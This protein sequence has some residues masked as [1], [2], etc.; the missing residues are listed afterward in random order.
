[1][2]VEW[3]PFV[4]RR[5]TGGDVVRG[6]DGFRGALRYGPS[7]VTPE[8]VA[9]T[10]LIVYPR[11]Y[12]SMLVTVQVPATVEWTQAV[13]VRGGFGAPTTP[14]DGVVIWYLAEALPHPAEGLSQQVL[15][16]PLTPGNFYYYSLF[17]WVEGQWVLAF[18]QDN[19]VPAEY[20]WP[21]FLFNTLPMFYQRSDD[22]Q[23]AD[24]RT[25]PLRVFARVLGYELDYTN[26]LANGVRDVYDVDRAPARLLKHL[27]YNFGVPDEP[28]LGEARQRSMLQ[29]LSDLNGLR[30][31]TLG[32]K[33]LIAAA[34][35]YDC[36]IHTGNNQLLSMD[37]GDFNGGDVSQ[38][39]MSPLLAT[40]LGWGVGHW[41][42]MTN[43]T[44]LAKLEDPVN[45]GVFASSH[46]VTTAILAK[47]TNPD[48]RLVPPGGQGA[49][50]V[51]GR[52]NDV[53]IACGPV[54]QNDSALYA[55]PVTPGAIYSFSCQ[56]MRTTWTEAAPASTPPPA[57][58]I[59][60]ALLWFDATGVFKGVSSGVTPPSGT[61]PAGFNDTGV[62]QAASFSASAPVVATAT[63]DARFVIPAIWWI[64]SSTWTAN[65]L[66]PAVRPTNG[67][68][69][70]MANFT[71]VAA[72]GE[73]IAAIGP[74]VFM[75]L[76]VVDKKLNDP[77]KSKLGAPGRTT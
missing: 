59:V 32:L 28:V 14:Q 49:L 63:Y 71:R 12:D 53:V 9:G 33:Q 36:D 13:L 67:R 57:A 47:N 30:G 56:L 24:G 4:V 31:T 38:P 48:V 54:L 44:V 66:T 42:P 15:D 60:L 69:V 3:R 1:M 7:V 46:T 26:T 21:E 23:A 34:T 45:P 74:D 22:M 40:D 77:A 10:N 39:G 72:A 8:D 55:I 19:A 5:T 17:L 16:T 70:S 25:G 68:Y 27:G 43:A 61:A 2:A 62:W 75:T 37:D 6:T 76:G 51:N 73:A 50:V 11:F 64:G 35:H 58:R 20:K 41:E 18:S 29:Q 65:S 52:G